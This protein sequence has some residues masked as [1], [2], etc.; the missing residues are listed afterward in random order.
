M[1]GEILIPTQTLSRNLLTVPSDY[2]NLSSRLSLSTD[3]GAK[4]VAI[5]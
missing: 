2:Q 4:A 3:Y 1:L 5:S